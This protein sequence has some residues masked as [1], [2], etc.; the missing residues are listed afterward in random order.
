MTRLRTAGFRDAGDLIRHPL[1][2]GAL[3]ALAAA[4][5]ALALAAA[6]GSPP[7]TTLNAFLDGVGTA[8]SVG[9]ALNGT[10]VIVLVGSGFIIAHRVGLVNVGGEGQICAG[11]VTATSVGLALPPAIGPWVGVP[12]L[13]GAAALGG[14]AWAAVAAALV[15]A[16]GVNEVICTLLLNFIALAGVVLCVHE[17]WLLRQPRTSAET[18]PQSAPLPASFQLPLLGI[19]RSP[20][21]LGIIV[22]LV[23]AA[24]T[25]LVLRRTALGV[26][27]EATGL[28]RPAAR[29]L[30]IATDRLRGGGLVVSGALAGVAGGLLVGAAPFLLVDGISSGYGFTGLVAGLLARGSLLAMVVVATSLAFLSSGGIAVQL[31]AGVPASL[32]QIAQ[33]LL[34]FFIASTAAWTVSHVPRRTTRAARATGEA[35]EVAP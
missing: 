26:R 24:G 30:G 23:A 22:A 15:L 31:F 9:A 8:H 32:T 1:A 35:G 25:A 28:S 20:A 6:A 16:R 10:A 12:V 33:A 18:L 29:R 21:T 34:V 13:L 14:A 5:T 3:S 11:A 27:L 2:L 17:D 7:G 19:E 4:V